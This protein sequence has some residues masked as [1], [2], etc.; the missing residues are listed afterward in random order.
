MIECRQG[1]DGIFL[2]FEEGGKIVKKKS[3]KRLAKSFLSFLMAVLLAFQ[4]TGP[5]FVQ[6]KE[7]VENIPR[8]VDFSR[9]AAL[10]S[11]EEAGIE[12][13]SGEEDGQT[14]GDADSQSPEDTGGTDEGTVPEEDAGQAEAPI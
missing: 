9:P 5:I 3:T 7:A 14:Q 13:T 11:I 10:I 4:G 2:F 12:D 8:T 6:A 1:N